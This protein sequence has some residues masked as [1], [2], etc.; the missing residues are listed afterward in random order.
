[1]NIR[2]SP[3][4]E[5]IKNGYSKGYISFKNQLLGRKISFFSGHMHGFANA[6][7]TFWM[8]C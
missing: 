2:F 8:Q 6:F 4:R 1:M 3:I 7:L 5:D